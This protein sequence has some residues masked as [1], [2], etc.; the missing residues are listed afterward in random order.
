MKLARVR[1]PASP[2]FSTCSFHMGIHGETLI[3]PIISYLSKGLGWLSASVLHDISYF[4]LKISAFLILRLIY[5]IPIATG[6]MN[7]NNKMLDWLMQWEMAC[8][9]FRDLD[10]SRIEVGLLG[11]GILM[12]R[13]RCRT[14]SW[15]A[16]A[17]RASHKHAVVGGCP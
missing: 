17:E 2:R 14:H 12:W 7:T 11:S 13:C 9:T 5:L 6:Q 8:L 16:P 15:K 10:E 4:Y 3:I 1:E